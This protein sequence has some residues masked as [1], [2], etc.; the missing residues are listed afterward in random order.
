[1]IKPSIVE[2]T[3]TAPPSKSFTHRAMILGAL[4]HSEFV[5][6]NPL[7]SEDTEA[8]LDALHS[9]GADI[10][11]SSGRLSIHCEE[12]KS[13]NPL[14]DTRNSGTTMRLMAGVAS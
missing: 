10:S 5:L 2:G 12:L 9:L 6:K 11:L 8:T 13:V 3:V 14:I 1:M 4:T 7:V